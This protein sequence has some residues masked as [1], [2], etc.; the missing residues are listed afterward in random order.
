MHYSPVLIGKGVVSLVDDPSFFLSSRG[1]SSPQAELE[2]TLKSFFVALPNDNQTTACRFPARLAWLTRVLDIKKSALPEYQCTHLNHWLDDLDADGLTLIF[3]VSMLNSPASMFGHTF[4]RLDRKA[5]KKPDLLAWTV[6]YAAHTAG[7]EGVSFALNGLLGGYPGKFSLEPYHTQVKAYSDIESRDMWEYELD[8]SQAEINSLLLHLWELLPAYFDYYFIDEN[9]SYQLLALL[10]VAR[11]ELDLTRNFY[12]D[13]TPAETVRALTD[14]PGLL[15]KVN[16]R[17]SLRQVVSE[18][19]ANLA[20]PDQELARALALGEINMR[21]EQFNIRD[22][23]IRAEILELA[24]DYVV[25]QDAVKRNEKM[26]L[27]LD[28]QAN[29]VLGDQF[30]N[31]ENSHSNLEQETLLYQ[32][33]AARSKVPV[34]SGSLEI[35]GPNYRPD[36]GHRGRRIGFRYGYDEPDQFLQMDF[37][38]AYH[39]LYDPSSGFIRGA[40]LEFFQP[41]F[42]YYPEKDDFQF[43]SVDFVNIISAPLRNYFVQPYSWEASAALKRYQFDEGNRPLM[44]D[45]KAGIGISYQLTGSTVASIFANTAINLSNEFDHNIALAG[46]GRV[47]LISTVTASWEAGLYGQAMQY[48]EGI[49]QTSY[50]LG[51]TQRFTLGADSAIVFDIA[52]KREFGDAFLST[53]LSLQLYF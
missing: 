44:W 43:E 25:Y 45:F 23:R 27:G 42:R 24:A 46:G 19:A 1:K 40:Q 6:S 50:E 8:Y 11:P 52:E 21:D 38:W 17:P 14:A 41:A 48:F 16:Y 37:R 30:P 2:A 39:D 12:L 4:L 15:K 18:R 20:R 7:D 35:V 10:D 33:L 49:D 31:D 9:C 26:L 13:A 51:M 32:L 36:Q 3:P 47:Q 22:D 5:E 29:H 34:K 53:Q 28:V